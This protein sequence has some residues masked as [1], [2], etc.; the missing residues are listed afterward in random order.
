MELGDTIIIGIDMNEDVQTGKLAKKLQ[1]LGIRE[2]IL[3]T[4]SAASPSATFIRNTLRTPIEGLWGTETVEVFRAR[5][6]PFNSGP[7]AAPSD[8]HRL[9][10]AEVCNCSILGKQIP[11]STKAI[12]AKGMKTK[13]P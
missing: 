4:H 3:L 10:W 6:L 5:Y 11:Y 8:G 1:A 9:I 13:D 2:L 12:Q 7:P